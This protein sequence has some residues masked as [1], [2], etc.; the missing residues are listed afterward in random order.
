[1]DYSPDYYGDIS[2]YQYYDSNDYYFPTTENFSDIWENC[3]LQSIKSIFPLLR[4]LIVLNFLFGLTVSCV[5]LPVT[6][7]DIFTGLIGIYLI[8]HLNSTQGVYIIVIYFISLYVILNVNICIKIYFQIS[9]GHIIKFI[10][11]LSLVVNEY[12][13]IKTEVFMEIRGILMIFVMKIFSLVDE[14]NI[15]NAFINPISYFGYIA[16]GANILFGPW[17]SYESYKAL[18][19]KKRKKGIYWVASI[20]R[21]FISCIFFLSLSN[22]FSTFIANDHNHIFLVS[23]RDAFSFRTSHYFISYLAE[24]GMLAAGFHTSSNKN[25]LWNFDIVHP[26]SVEFPTSLSVVAT[27]WNIPMHQFLKY[28]IYL[29]LKP[30]GTFLA[31][32]GTF[33]ASSFLHGL[34]L[35]VSVVLLSLGIFSYVQIKARS[36][37]SKLLNACLN[38]KPCKNCIHKFKKIGRAH[39]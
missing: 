20:L 16:C 18:Y 19:N 25:K 8:S 30:Y 22:C 14:S 11:F 7:F 13:F 9:C 33:L 1:M 12:R 4:N 37:V 26:I 31:I 5:K 10:V 34:E 24:T 2:D 21:S 23:Y 27:K 17:I 35:N 29:P 38:V 6:L 3:V 28:Y 39:V 32:F 36:K 15:K